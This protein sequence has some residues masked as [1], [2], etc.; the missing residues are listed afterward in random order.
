MISFLFIDA[1]RV[2]RGGQDQLFTLLRGLCRRGHRVHLICHPGTLLEER[3][4]E[5]G[6]EVHAFSMRSGTGLIYFF[7]ILRGMLRVLPQIL[8]FNT[9]KPILLANVASR[10]STVR[11]RLIFRR[12]N[13][14]LRR[15]LLTRWKY[16]WG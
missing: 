7:R 3:A 13:F 9:P 5:A 8:A 14:P 10:F 1:E 15:N 11:A 16:N 4:R 12:V 6:V 2:W